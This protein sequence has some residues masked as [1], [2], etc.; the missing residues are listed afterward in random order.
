[1]ELKTRVKPSL[2]KNRRD[3]ESLLPSKL[4]YF[5]AKA[6]TFITPRQV[7][8]P[9]EKLLGQS[10]TDD[11]ETLAYRSNFAHLNSL[12]LYTNDGEKS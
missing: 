5:I 11:T 7:F 2:I 4:K 3:R 12:R 10:R 9:R 6:A 1:M 8:R